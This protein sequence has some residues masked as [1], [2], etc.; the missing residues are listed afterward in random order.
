MTPGAGIYRFPWQFPEPGCKTQLPLPAGRFVHKSVYFSFGRSIP[1]KIPD[2][3][4]QQDSEQTAQAE[5]LFRA[6]MKAE[7]LRCTSE[8]IDVLREIY[9][10]DTHL[11][12]DGL[13][14]RLKEKGTGISRATVYHTLDLLFRLNLVNRI[15][16]GH[17]HTHYEKAHGVAN[18]LHIV[19]HRCG[20]VEEAA[21]SRLAGM[22]E[23][24]C[25]EQGFTL[26]SFSL[27][28]FGE[29]RD[30]GECEARAAHGRDGRP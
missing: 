26:G 9:R 27:Q 8:R 6:F 30:R 5:S 14:S 3:V 21:S 7:G 22:V 17:H 13:F 19:C 11:D 29:C 28:V 15:D 20:K 24:L 10:S 23:K 2:N 18:H 16:L 1:R 12:A 25:A 4:Q